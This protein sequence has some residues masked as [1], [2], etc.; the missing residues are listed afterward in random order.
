M[1]NWCYN[2]AKFTHKD[3]AMIAR[4]AKGF[5]EGK[6][7]GEF[8][9]TPPELLEDVPVGENYVERSAAREAENEENFGHKDWYHWNIDNWGTKW[10]INTEEADDIELADGAL[11]ISLSFDTAW[12]PPIEFYRTMTDGFDFEVEAYYNE[13]GMTFCGKYTSEDDD[14][15]YEYSDQT[16]DWVRENIPNDIHEHWGI[17]D[18]LDDMAEEEDDDDIG[19]DDAE[20]GDE[21]E[22]YGE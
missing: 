10:D 15:F 3:P 21:N 17:A 14:D 19:M 20:D 1:P 6:L 2:T 9:P 8:D 18:L 11:E 12:S 16:G 5:N 22:S 7:F 13:E 4:V